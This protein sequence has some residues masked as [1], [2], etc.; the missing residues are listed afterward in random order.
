MRRFDPTRTLRNSLDHVGERRRAAGRASIGLGVTDLA[1]LDDS[2]AA[3][4]VKGMSPCSTDTT[5][6][7]SLTKSEPADVSAA[8]SKGRVIRA[9]LI[10]RYEYSESESHQERSDPSRQQSTYAGALGGW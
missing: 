7:I 6:P 2:P 10:G 4:D 9:G 3:L 8:C 5:S 1:H